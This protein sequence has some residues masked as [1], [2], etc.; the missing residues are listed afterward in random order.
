MPIACCPSCGGEVCLPAMSSGSIRCPRC[1]ATID[2][3]ECDAVK[4]RRGL[5]LSLA[6]DVPA[7]FI[8]MVVGLVM[9]RVRA[10]SNTTRRI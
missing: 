5:W 10:G 6:L 2:K 7:I 8:A 1:K 3:S 9:G 4:S